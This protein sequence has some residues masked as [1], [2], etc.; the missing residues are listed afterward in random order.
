M[1][2]A[3]RRVLPSDSAQKPIFELPPRVR[4]VG[5][6]LAVLLDMLMAGCLTLFYDGAVVAILFGIEFT[7]YSKNGSRPSEASVVFNTA[8]VVGGLA[9]VG[10]LLRKKYFRALAVLLGLLPLTLLIWYKLL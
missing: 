3:P 1:R 2:V 6:V 5:R 9:V 4:L 7:H 8:L 10:L